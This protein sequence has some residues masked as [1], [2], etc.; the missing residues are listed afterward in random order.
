LKFN[1][2]L[3]NVCEV[4]QRIF[5]K[6]D[7]IYDCG[8]RKVIDDDQTFN[9]SLGAYH[10][11]TVSMSDLPVKEYIAM[12]HVTCMEGWLTGTLDAAK[13]I[14]TNLSDQD[15]Q[16]LYEYIHWTLKHKL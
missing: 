8:M 4:C 9:Y 5:H 2:D 6:D 14:A 1:T 3:R 13:E 12:A 11:N 15:C 16:K 10:P 7:K